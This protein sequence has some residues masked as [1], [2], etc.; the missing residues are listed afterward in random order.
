MSVLFFALN[1]LYAEKFDDLPHTNQNN[2]GRGAAYTKRY[3]ES[4]G[5]F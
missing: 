1:I 5:E 3:A 2:F 4:F